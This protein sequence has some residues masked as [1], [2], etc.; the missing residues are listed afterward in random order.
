MA[1]NI[2]KLIQNKKYKIAYTTGV[3][4]LFHIG[5][6]NLIRKT[7]DLAEKVIVG[8][9]TDKLVYQ[10]KGKYPFIPFKERIE[11][12]KSLK[13][14]DMVIPQ[15]DKNKQ[16]VVDQYKID[17][18]TVGSDW[19]GRYPKVTCEI[20]Y[21]DYTSSTSSTKLQQLIKTELKNNNI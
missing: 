1:D 11:I 8:V 21:F 5:H 9:S 3:F 4:D 14:V 12:V 20:V 17:V 19:K 10:A 6:L 7:K 15:I 18:I 16:A 2:S 13:Y